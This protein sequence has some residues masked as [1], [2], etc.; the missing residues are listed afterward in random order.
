MIPSLPVC[1]ESLA[2]R[3]VPRDRDHLVVRKFLVDQGCQE[4]QG[5]LKVLVVQQHLVDQ[6]HQHFLM[7]QFLL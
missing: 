5:T 4:D 6:C 2:D 3:V 7:F 1:P